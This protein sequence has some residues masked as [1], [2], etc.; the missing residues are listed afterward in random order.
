MGA[1]REL[2]D[3]CRYSAD[4]PPASCTT[5]RPA[6]ARPRRRP[7]PES[8]LGWRPAARR[9]SRGP[10]QGR[11]AGT[12]RR[13]ARAGRC[14]RRRP[15]CQRPARAG[16]PRPLGAALVRTL[17]ASSARVTSRRWCGA[18]MPSRCTCGLG[19][20][21]P[22]RVLPSAAIVRCGRPVGAW[23]PVGQPPAPCRGPG[24]Q[25]GPGRAYSGVAGPAARPGSGD[26]TA[27]R[28]VTQALRSVQDR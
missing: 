5:C 21:P 15:G 11:R 23:P 12:A 1:T 4:N 3:R 25:P 20:P 7:W 6:P 27:S 9:G 14:G 26:R 19:C 17:Q 28:G 13:L 16:R 18:S 10:W 24:W 2:Q 22:R 8:R